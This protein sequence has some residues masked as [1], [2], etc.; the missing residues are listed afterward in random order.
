M[1]EDDAIEWVESEATTVAQLFYDMK[2][3]DGA[4]YMASHGFTTKDK[5]VI[6]CFWNEKKRRVV[7]VYLRNTEDGRKVL[8]PY[9]GKEE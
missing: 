5:K 6:H 7:R 9:F 8:M 2:G 1:E 4:L 3:G